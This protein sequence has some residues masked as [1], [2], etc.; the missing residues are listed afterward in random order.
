MADETHP[1]FPVIKADM[2]SLTAILGISQ[3]GEAASML[4]TL[5]MATASFLDMK[6]MF[7]RESSGAVLAHLVTVARC[8]GQDGSGSLDAMQALAETL[9]ASK[10]AGGVDA[11]D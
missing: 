5:V 6:G 8:G 9:M 2:E 3:S 7:P 4:C 10:P 1:L 11:A